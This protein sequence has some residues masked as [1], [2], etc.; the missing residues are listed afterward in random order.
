[1]QYGFE[2][3]SGRVIGEYDASQRGAI[4]FPVGSE[5]GFAE[6]LTDFVQSRPAGLDDLPG[7]DVGVDDCGSQI[8]K[9]ICNRRL[10]AGDAAGQPDSQESVFSCHSEKQ[11]QVRILDRFAPEHRQ[12]AGSGQVRTERNRQLPVAAAEDDHR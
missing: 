1:M 7:N 6:L 4:E 10:A 11:I 8:G 9:E 2:T 5:N 3:L 12:P